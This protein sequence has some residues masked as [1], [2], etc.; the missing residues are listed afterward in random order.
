MRLTIEGTKEMQAALKDISDD[1]FQAADAA[2]I[3]GAANLDMQASCCACNRGRT[4]AISTAG[5]VSCIGHPH[6]AKHQ[7]QTLG[8]CSAP[9]TMS[10]KAD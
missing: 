6:R 1:L 2:V 10:G 7:R 5:A 9:F 3:E 8:R 4:P